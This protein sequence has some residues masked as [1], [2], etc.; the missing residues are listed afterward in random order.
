MRQLHSNNAFARFAILAGVVIVTLDISLT[1]TAL[2]AIALGVASAPATAIWIVNV[3]YLAVVAALL[4]LAALGE[5][6]GHRRIFFAGLVIFAVGSLISGLASSLPALMGGRVLLGV[7]AAAVSATTPALIRSI[8]PSDRLGRGLGL[9]ALVVGV[10]F[11]A[12]PPAASAILALADWPWLYFMNAPVAMLALGL[13]VKALPETQRNVRRFDP[14]AGLL[15][16]ATMACLLFVFAGLAELSAPPIL[17]ALAIFALSC[18]LLLRR[19][20]GRAA[21]ILA[22][23][24]FRRPAFALSSLTAVCSFSVQGAVFVALPFLLLAMGF[25]QVEAGLLILPWPATLIVM[26]LLAARLAER[27]APGLLAGIGLA[28]LAIGL[29]LLA[30]MPAGADESAIAWRLVLCGIGFGLF[31]S[32]NMVA[33]MASAP[34]DRSGG[35]GAILALSRQFG[36]SIGAGV[37]A[38]WL[39]SGMENGLEA[40]IWSAVG[41]ALVG[42]IVSLSRLLPSVRNGALGLDVA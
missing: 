27:V 32:P 14:V 16:A 5:I 19:E 37:V 21:P 20:A 1:S 8:Y 29:T 38:F 31:Q 18:A 36:Q 24:L 41:A 28:L 15:S 26:T 42:C 35:A 25:S 9:Y 6:Y 12:G 34:K 13:A 11:A 33:F 23:D 22:A 3:Y 40:A 39:A 30:T 7:G 4:S 17:G 2:P 10:A